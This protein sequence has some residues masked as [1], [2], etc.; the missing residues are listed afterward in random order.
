ME[1]STPEILFS[2][3]FFIPFS[4]NITQVMQCNF[5]EICKCQCYRFQ[6]FLKEWSSKMKF[7]ATS[8]L[9]ELLVELVDW[10]TFVRTGL[11]LFCI[12]SLVYFCSCVFLCLFLFIFCFSYNLL[13]YSIQ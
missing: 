8:L 11:W 5:L 9:S 4:M 3:Y 10:E 2:S 13:S 7:L 12:T 1:Y 6:I